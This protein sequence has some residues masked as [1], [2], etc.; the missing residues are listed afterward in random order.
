MLAGQYFWLIT[1]RNFERRK[2]AGG[3]YYFHHL[4]LPSCYFPVNIHFIN[5]PVSKN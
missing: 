1:T 3:E 5:Q 2:P 4:L